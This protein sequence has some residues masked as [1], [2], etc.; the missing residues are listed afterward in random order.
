MSRHVVLGAGP[1]GRLVASELSTRHEVVVVTRSGS[2]VD[3]ADS[4]ALSAADPAL[5]EVLAG[6]SSVVVAT[7]P[8]YEQWARE[9]PPLLTNVIAAASAGTGV[10]LIG[11]LYGYSPGT[12]P[13]SA[14][15]PLAPTTRKGRVRAE[16]WQQLLAAHQAGIVRAAEIRASDYV[17]PQAVDTQAHAGARLVQP[18]LAGRAAY[19]LGDPQAPHSWAA[20]A[21]IARTAVAVA[22]SDDAWGRPWVVPS[23]PPRSI[24]QLAHDLAAEAGARPPTVK[25]IP[26]PVLRL[27]GLVNPVIREVA[28]L[29]YQFDRP[30]ISDGSQTTERLGIHATPWAEVIT[31]MAE[32]ARA[33]RPTPRAI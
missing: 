32:Q 29:T 28:E 26:R 8:P 17:G 10:I 18:V 15:E 27:A 2:T 9:W 20:V 14:D 11:N 16:L 31:G 33:R 23:T 13:M 30:F 1:I 6:A 25:R 12:A 24:S 4:I 19:V 7:N 21:D 22:T 5:R 3:G